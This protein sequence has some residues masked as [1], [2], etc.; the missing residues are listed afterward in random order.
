MKDISRPSL[1]KPGELLRHAV[2]RLCLVA[3]LLL[4]LPSCVSVIRKDLMDAGTRKFSFPEVIKNPML[5]EGKL[6]ILGGRIVET[7]L[8]EQGS[9]IEAIYAPV[10]WTGALDDIL[11]PTIRFRALCPREAGILDPVVYS[12]GREVT[13]AAV[14]ERMEPGRI[15]DMEYAFPYFRIRQVYLWPKRVPVVY[16]PYYYGPYWGPR[17]YRS[18]GPWYYGGTGYYYLP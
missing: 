16:G 9:L 2:V 7:R 6:F 17:P 18:W 14:F 4:A 13:L 11:M 12:K 1:L 10:D 8:T 5:Y 3:L 15:D